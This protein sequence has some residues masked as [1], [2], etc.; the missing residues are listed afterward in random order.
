LRYD[1]KEDRAVPGY[2][3]GVNACKPAYLDAITGW[4]GGG[5]EL[6]VNGYGEMCA[7]IIGATSRVHTASS[8]RHHQPKSISYGRQRGAIHGLLMGDED[9]YVH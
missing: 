7:N 5:G 6:G 9:R 3:A 2:R 4:R 8:R 1:T